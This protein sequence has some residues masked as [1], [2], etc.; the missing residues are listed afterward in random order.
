[1]LRRHTK[2]FANN[3]E[4]M[5]TTFKQIGPSFANLKNILQQST[6]RK[7]N[8]NLYKTGP[9]LQKK[10]TLKGLVKRANGKI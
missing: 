6:Q 9:S 1:M 7:F 8:I 5:H 2:T 4:H 3:I 10:A